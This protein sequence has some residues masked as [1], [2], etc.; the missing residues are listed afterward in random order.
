MIG[1]DQRR[2]GGLGTVDPRPGRL[3]PTG[4][5]RDRDDLEPRRM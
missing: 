2:M 3:D 4:V 1:I 5:E